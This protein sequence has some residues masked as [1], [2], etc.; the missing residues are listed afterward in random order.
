MTPTAV[1][2]A[3]GAALF[4]GDEIVLRAK[5]KDLTGGHVLT[6][7]LHPPVREYWFVGAA[8]ERVV[9]GAASVAAE[10]T[11]NAANAA[12]P[13]A[14]DPNPPAAQTVPGPA[15]LREQAITHVMK[16]G[17]ERPAAEKIVEEQGTAT[18]LADRDAEL[19]AE[20]AKNAAQI[21]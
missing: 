3:K 18:I 14:V 9:R 7:C 15:S 2:D 1:T 5:V 8:V 10:K 4:I 11:E 17:Y 6:E 16:A 20:K 21:T 12:A 13:A 19:E